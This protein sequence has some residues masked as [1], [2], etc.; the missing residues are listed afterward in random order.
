ML[1]YFCI[2]KSVK[3]TGKVVYFTATAPY[4]LLFAFLIRA[5]TLEGAMDGILYLL[6]P[7]WCKMLDSKVQNT[8]ERKYSIM[9]L[10]N[11]T[12]LITIDMNTSNVFL[13][14]RYG[15]MPQL[16]FS[17]QLGLLLDF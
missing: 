4:L 7:R 9:R 17:I 8:N 1:V 16:K 14:N 10:F 3:A 15:Y 11:F 13:I 12:A 6:S 2:W 5:V